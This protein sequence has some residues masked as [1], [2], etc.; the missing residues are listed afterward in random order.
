MVSYKLC[1]T[2]NIFDL[3]FLLDYIFNKKQVEEKVDFWIRQYPYKSHI[4]RVID[5]IADNF[6]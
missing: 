1:I 2:E 4:F 6:L 3:Y 5:I